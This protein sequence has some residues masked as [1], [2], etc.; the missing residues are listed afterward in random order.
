M[1]KDPFK[2]VNTEAL[3]SQLRVVQ[4][5]MRTH[6]ERFKKILYFY[7]KVA[8]VDSSKVI[9]NKTQIPTDINYTYRHH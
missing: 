4:S 9:N 3:E 1:P 7:T 2:P 6:P 5:L 8:K